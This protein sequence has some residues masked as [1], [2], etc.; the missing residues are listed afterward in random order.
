MLGESGE[1][2][3]AMATS[4]AVAA[5]AKGPCQRM[6]WFRERGEMGE[7]ERWVRER[8]DG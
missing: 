8:G 3:T 4:Q 5:A 2:A 7:R 1:A 6:G